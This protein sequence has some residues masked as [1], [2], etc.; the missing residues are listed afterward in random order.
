MN[1]GNNIKRDYDAANDENR[2]KGDDNQEDKN[3]KRSDKI[4]NNSVKDK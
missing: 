3:K 4:D 1:T 2:K